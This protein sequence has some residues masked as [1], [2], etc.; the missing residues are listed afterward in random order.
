MVERVL[1]LPAEELDT[2][3]NNPMPVLKRVAK[4]PCC[5]YFE[6][7]VSV[8]WEGEKGIDVSFYCPNCDLNSCATLPRIEDWKV[9]SYPNINAKKFY[10]PR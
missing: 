5:G 4:C 7:E 2:D 9:D 1:T 3:E 8:W 6:T 10:P